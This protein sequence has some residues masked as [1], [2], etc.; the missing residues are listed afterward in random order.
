MKAIFVHVPLYKGQVD[1]QDGMGMNL[2]DMS[3]AVLVVI[4]S[5]LQ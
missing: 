4:K 3:T 5:V 2:H 1:T